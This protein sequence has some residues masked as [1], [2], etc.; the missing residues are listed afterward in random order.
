V[1][2]GDTNCNVS[3]PAKRYEIILGNYVYW[4][5]YCLG[6]TIAETR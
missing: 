1:I 4:I 6:V 5:C 2:L 3:F